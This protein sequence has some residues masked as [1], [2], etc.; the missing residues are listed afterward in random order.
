MLGNYIL[1]GSFNARLM[2]EVRKERGLTYDI[3]S[4]H[5]GDIQTPGNWTLMATFSPS[6][7]DKGLEATRQVLDNWY[8][9]GVSEE[10]VDAAIE[11]LTGSY[12]V[13][14][15]TTGRV[16]GQLHSFL[17]RG[18][19]A[20]YI[21][22]YPLELE[23]VTTEQ[24]NRSIKKYLDPSKAKLVIAGSLQ[25]GSA[26]TN[27]A[28]NKTLSVRIDTP[29]AGWQIEIE[30]I[31]RTADHLLVISRLNQN[32]EVAAQVITTVADSVEIPSGIDLPVQHYILGKTWD[33][34]DTG[35][36]TFIDSVDAIGTPLEEAE[37]I[38]SN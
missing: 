3:R 29:H 35:K 37:R 19:D 23:K 24:V 11:T 4:S 26:P 36:Y 22:Q 20:E 16:A 18:L 8:Q 2:S 28:K 5:Q 21:D 32:E 7:L 9:N 10:E 13:G 6:M 38:Y 14:L 30:K 34:G 1:G 15:S 31:Y 27:A 25:N 12:L 33:W 17:Q